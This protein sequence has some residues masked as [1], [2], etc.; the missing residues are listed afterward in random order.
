MRFFFPDTPEL[1]LP[2]GHRFPRGKYRLLKDQ[3]ERDGVLAGATLAPSPSAD[4]GDIVRAH[5]PAY[6]AAVANGD[7]TRAAQ[8]LIGLP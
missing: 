8:R 7:L 1:P 2:Q 3:L 6:V 4:D 5:D